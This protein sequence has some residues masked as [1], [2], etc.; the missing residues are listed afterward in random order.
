MTIITDCLRSDRWRV[1]AQRK[2]QTL[3]DL[4]LYAKSYIIDGYRIS[5]STVDGLDTARIIAPPGA[6]IT[7]FTD[8]KYEYRYAD[9]YGSDFAMGLSR[10]AVDG[11]V[12]TNLLSAHG[13]LMYHAVSD[14][15]TPD[16]VWYVAAA[17]WYAP[18]P[19]IPASPSTDPAGYL[20]GSFSMSA[21]NPA[22]TP[23][24]GSSLA[25]NACLYSS[26][27]VQPTSVKHFTDAGI[28]VVRDA[29]RFGTAF[30]FQGTYPEFKGKASFLRPVWGEDGVMLYVIHYDAS[31]ACG[32]TLGKASALAFFQAVSTNPFGSDG[33]YDSGV[34][35][36]ATIAGAL[37]VVPP[38]TGGDDTALTTALS[39]LLSPHWPY[40]YAPHQRGVFSC[41]DFD[42]CF[43]GPMPDTSVK[44]LVLSYDGTATVRPIV[45]PLYNAAVERCVITEVSHGWYSCIVVA[46]PDVFNDWKS[47]DT[48]A[49]YYGSPFGGWTLLAHPTG[50][51]I[52]HKTIKADALITVAI[53]LMYD[54]DADE[55]DLYEMDS[56][57]SAGW[58]KRGKVGAGKL[59]EADV[60][61][62][63][64]H[65]FATAAA[66]DTPVAQLL[67][68]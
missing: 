29:L 40:A 24:L 20:A 31:A 37:G 48:T 1:F 8:G 21:T 52:K 43:W 59:T 14:Y 63:G 56:T 65:P 19:N 53:S 54:D 26:H 17:S 47:G 49:V 9:Q 10:P 44:G 62:F 7:D 6:V 12:P 15:S 27:H 30:N 13:D 18:R 66:L 67:P 16:G 42:V 3:K 41:N 28:G 38:C 55:T 23:V 2:I 36:Q 60:A 35:N 68:V 33:V 39:D 32:S 58:V 50:T 64:A 57:N 46:V 4:G 11:I 51:I 34:V 61:I 5:V 45:L 25:R 22:G